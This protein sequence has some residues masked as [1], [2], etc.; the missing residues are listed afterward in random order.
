M[1]QCRER[2][3]GPH[4]ERSQDHRPLAHRRGDLF[5]DR[6]LLILRRE[7]IGTEE[8]EL[9]AQQADAVGARGGGAPSVVHAGRVA[10]DLDA[11]TI[12]GDGRLGI[13]GGV[14]RWTHGC[15]EI[16]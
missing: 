13:A 8:Q 3:I 10:A 1:G 7:A 6:D 14:S 2:L 16:R 12:A 4:V 15:D 9:A 11:A 5:E